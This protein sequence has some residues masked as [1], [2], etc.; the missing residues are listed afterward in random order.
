MYGA[1]EARLMGKGFVQGVAID[2][3]CFQRLEECEVDK[4]RLFALPT[5]QCPDTGQAELRS[6]GKSQPHQDVAG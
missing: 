1:G 6:T 5:S 2:R 4:I 3:A